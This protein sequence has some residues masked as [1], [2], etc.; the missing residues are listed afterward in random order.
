MYSMAN[1]A[2]HLRIVREA[3]NLS[4]RDLTRLLRINVNSAS[5]W[6]AACLF[7][8]CETLVNLV[9]ICGVSIGS[10]FSEPQFSRDLYSMTA[11]RHNLTLYRQINELK[12]RDLAKA[13][14]C[15]PCQVSQY[16]CGHIS[17]RVETLVRLA[18]ELD[19][20]LDWLFKHEESAHGP[21]HLANA[22]TPNR[23]SRSLRQLARRQL[24]VA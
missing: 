15:A 11:F 13:S 14:G 2:D 5:R 7:P 24:Q 20:D 12:Q 1:F 18:N 6:E 16:E 17:P 4:Q 22:E 3:R 23:Q 21:F 19:I 8:R 10:M 9:N